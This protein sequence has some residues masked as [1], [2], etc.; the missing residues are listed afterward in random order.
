MPLIDQ[1]RGAISKNLFP[2]F[3]AEG[4]WDKKLNKISHHSYLS[5]GQ[6]SLASIKGPLFLH[7][8]SWAEN[9]RHILRAIEKN[10]GVSSL[11]VGLHGDPTS[12]WNQ[13]IICMAQAMAT[14]REAKNVLS[15]HFY[16][17]ASANVWGNV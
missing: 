1:A 9:D 4:S 2:L 14:S 13:K 17:S 10:K 5:K 7:G 11:F 6:R 3:V 15:V 16:D 8:V 12:Q